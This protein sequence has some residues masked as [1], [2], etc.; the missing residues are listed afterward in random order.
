[1]K[2]I[3]RNLQTMILEK[4]GGMATI[5]LNT[6][7]RLNAM[8]PQQLLDLVEVCAELGEDE[9]IRAVVITDA[10]RAFLAGGDVES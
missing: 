7:E 4:D 6:P 10:G 5:T 3:K 2:S 1:M 9:E 8:S